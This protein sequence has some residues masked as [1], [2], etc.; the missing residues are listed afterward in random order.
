M[1]VLKNVDLDVDVVVEESKETLKT[2]DLVFEGVKELFYLTY[3]KDATAHEL[4]SKKKTID[5]KIEKVKL[6]NKKLHQ[7]KEAVKKE[8]KN[9]KEK[10]TSA[11]K[12]L[13][14]S[15]EESK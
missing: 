7:M 15:L 4:K 14:K 12:L 13:T 8:V 5:K 9:S 10:L 2:K 3:N 11:I 1:K 6:Y